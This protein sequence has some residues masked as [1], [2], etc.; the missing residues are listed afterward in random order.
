M[1]PYDSF[2]VYITLAGILACSIYVAFKPYWIIRKSELISLRLELAQL[3]ADKRALMAQI[4]MHLNQKIVRERT[5][6]QRFDFPMG[7]QS[8]KIILP[9]D[10]LVNG[11]ICRRSISWD[12]EDYRLF[13][14]GY[15]Y[16]RRGRKYG[17]I[18]PKDK[19][20]GDIELTGNDLPFDY[21]EEPVQQSLTI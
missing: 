1:T 12:K 7:R 17:W 11:E 15:L 3:K 9:Y 6:Q 13:Q 14:A 10:I 5:G 16:I 18:D 2:V 20:P 4:D 19:Q 8:T 21:I